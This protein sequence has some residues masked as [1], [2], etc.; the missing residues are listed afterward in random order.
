M[1][2]RSFRSIFALNP[3][4]PR[5]L[6]AIGLMSRPILKGICWP[7]KQTGTHTVVSLCKN[8]VPIYLKTP[9]NL[10][11]M[12]K[13]CTCVAWSMHAWSAYIWCSFC[14]CFLLFFFSL[15]SPKHFIQC[16]SKSWKIH[17]NSFNQQIMMWTSHKIFV[18]VVLCYDK[19]SYT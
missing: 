8:G 15:L 9:T 4:A 7:K 19:Y 13:D 16:K 2:L 12:N 17:T 5:N 10:H 1:G 3:F 14:C 6:G 11:I 18:S